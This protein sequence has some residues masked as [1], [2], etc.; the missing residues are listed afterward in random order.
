[1]MGKARLTLQFPG[2]HDV[3]I[4]YDLMGMREGLDLGTSGT[5]VVGGQA[6]VFV[7][8]S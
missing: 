2:S 4:P 6:V 3:M 7:V 5:T 1:M 8:G